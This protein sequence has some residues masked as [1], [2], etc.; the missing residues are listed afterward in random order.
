MTQTAI[1]SH[2]LPLFVHGCFVLH[3]FR[4]NASQCKGSQCQDCGLFAAA[5]GFLARERKELRL[6]KTIEMLIRVDFLHT[7][8]TI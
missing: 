8:D 5:N 2:G 3:V 1:F 6:L 4:L 7:Q